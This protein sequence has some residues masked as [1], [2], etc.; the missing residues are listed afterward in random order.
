MATKRE[1]F[2]ITYPEDSTR[3]LDFIMQKSLEDEEFAAQFRGARIHAVARFVDTDEE[4]K[5]IREGFIVGAAFS[6]EQ[7]EQQLANGW[8]FQSKEMLV[9]A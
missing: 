6:L 9:S 7:Q 1:T 8:G 5:K 4:G 2:P 3:V